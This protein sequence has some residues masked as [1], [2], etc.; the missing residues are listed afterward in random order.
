MAEVSEEAKLRNFGGYYGAL[1]DVTNRGYQA[2]TG[3]ASGGQTFANNATNIAMQGGQ[4]QANLAIAKG[5]NQANTAGDLASWIGWGMGNMG[6]MGG[7]GSTGTKSSGGGTAG[8]LTSGI[9]SRIS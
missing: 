3:I 1:G 6:S 8:R 2:D 7:G 5:Q 9:R 4:N